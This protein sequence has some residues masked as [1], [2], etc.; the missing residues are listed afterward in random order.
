MVS[1]EVIQTTMVRLGQ[2]LDKHAVVSVISRRS[3]KNA[4]AGERRFNYH[5]LNG[6]EVF[7]GA[8]S[9]QQV[10]FMRLINEPVAELVDTVISKITTSSSVRVRVSSGLPSKNSPTKGCFLLLPQVY[11]LIS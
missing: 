11:E 10:R 4:A 5:L 7:Y 8:Y 9:L 1:G 3:S 6:V 2:N